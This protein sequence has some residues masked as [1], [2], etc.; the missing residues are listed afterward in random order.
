MPDLVAV[1]S[2]GGTGYVYNYELEGGPQAWISNIDQARELADDP[3]M[4]TPRTL[5]A[6][7]SDGVTVVG[8]FTVG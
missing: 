3:A 6:Y 4:Q 5:T 8:T 7:K 2:T 1:E